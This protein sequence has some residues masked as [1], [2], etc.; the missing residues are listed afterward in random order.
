MKAKDCLFRLRELR[1]KISGGDE[2]FDEERIAAM[3]FAEN[4]IVSVPIN[5][6]NIYFDEYGFAHDKKLEKPLTNA[7]RIRAMTDEKLAAY[8]HSI[9]DCDP[10]CPCLN[11]CYE[12]DNEVIPY[13]PCEKRLLDWLQKEADE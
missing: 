13:V 2:K 7:D 10:R 12:A 9:C 4:A 5:C 11:D 1:E 3:L 6:E 8:I